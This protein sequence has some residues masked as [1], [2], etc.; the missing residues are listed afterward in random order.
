MCFSDLKLLKQFSQHTRKSGVAS[1]MDQETLAEMAHYVPGEKPTVPGHEAVVRIVKVGEGVDHFKVGERYVVETD[2]RWLP[3]E[4]S[5]AAF[6]YNFEGGL[7]EYVL[8]DERVITSPDGELMLIPAPEDLS[9]SALALVEPWACV[10]HAYG[11]RQRRE[12]KNGGSVLVAH[13]AG[14]E[15]PNI[16]AC[17]GRP[18]SVVYADR[19]SLAQIAGSGFDDIVYFGADPEMVE[20]LSPRLNPGGLMVIVQGGLKLAAPSTRPSGA[21]ITAAFASSEPQAPTPPR[22]S[23]RYRRAPSFAPATESTSSAPP[24]RWAPCT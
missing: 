21:S 8:F 5:N 22:R 15:V 24:G 3:T 10:E 12:L 17:P 20:K 6:G 16:K 19:D 4:K 18:A 11:E 13:D 7:Q 1:G 14:V 9:A 2:Y 23:P